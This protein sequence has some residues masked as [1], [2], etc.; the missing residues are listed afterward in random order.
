MECPGSLR[1]S[2]WRL[3]LIEY[4]EMDKRRV[5][6][7]ERVYIY[8]YVSFAMGVLFLLGLVLFT[9]MALQKI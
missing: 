9:W 7:M 3:G 6:T 8:G 5:E 4:K 1:S 2:V